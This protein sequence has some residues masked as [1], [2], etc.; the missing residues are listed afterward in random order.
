MSPDETPSHRPL[1]PSG[2]SR[3]ARD[4][5]L[6]SLGVGLAVALLLLVNTLGFRYHH[7]GDWTKTRI[8]SLSEQT[9]NVLAGLERD[10]T[11]TLFL[12]P[13]SR[14]YEPTQELLDRYQAASPRIAV[15]SIDPE[16]NPVEAQRLAQQLELTSAAVVFE[17][18]T[19]R[20]VIAADALAELDFQGVE[21]GREPEIAAFKGEERFTSALVALSQGDKPKIVFTTGHGEMALDDLSPGGLKALQD[22][23]GRDNV[24]FEEWS[25]LG[26]KALPDGADLVVVAGPKTA[27]V[28]PEL[29]LLS[30]Y[31]DGGGRLLVLLDPTFGPHGIAGGL[32]PTGLEAWLARYGVNVGNNV[33]V[34]PTL[35][36]PGFGGETFFAAD[37]TAHPVTRSLAGS[38]AALLVRGARSLAVGA[39]PSGYIATE[40]VRTSKDAWGLTRFE[41]P[42][43]TGPEEG[44]P[45]GPLAL[46]VAIEPAGHDHDHEAG[47]EHSEDEA[48]AAGFRLIVV[49]DADFVTE[50]LLAAGPANAILASNLVNS[51]VERDTLLGIPPKRP[52]QVRLSM[53]GG[54]QRAAIL[55]ALVGLP[56]L[57][58]LAG[59]SVWWRRRKSP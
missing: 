55:L 46:A 16:R 26:A 36:Y 18:G 2:W 41:G 27:L 39:A 31:L 4:G 19:D 54:E 42:P 5:S 24:T 43:A 33:V 20:R 11:V 48:E 59:V 9:E 57:S 22:L 1:R 35:A 51:L 23:V 12:T 38:N 32:A 25:S 44:E 13:G 53:S 49:G 50:S 45:R 17:A 14:L 40:L 7:R 34:D 47:E 58:L 8:Y 29:V 28:E 56:G 10:V 3:A 15:R 6:T 30:T 21:L 37:Y 52:E